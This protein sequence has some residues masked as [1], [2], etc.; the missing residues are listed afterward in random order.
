MELACAQA[1]DYASATKRLLEGMRWKLRPRRV[2]SGLAQMLLRRPPSLREL[3]AL[4]GFANDYAWFAELVRRLF[5]EEA[6]AMLLGNSGSAGPGGA[7]CP[8][9]PG[10]PLPSV[11]PVYR[12]LA[13]TT[14]EEPP[15]TW[16]RRGIP[17]DLMGFGYDDLHEMWD[18]YREGLSALALLAQPP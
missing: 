10:S 16:L 8:A 14:G 13:P 7:F 15:W 3:V 12:I 11:R 18:G 2:L 5:P 1:Q 6:E 17:F 4:V 9:L